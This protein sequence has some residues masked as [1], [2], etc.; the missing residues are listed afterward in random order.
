MISY[1]AAVA[2]AL[3]QGNRENG[4][5]FY[6]NTRY[7]TADLIDSQVLLSHKKAQKGLQIYAVSD[8]T[9]AESYDEETSAIIVKN[10]LKYHKILVDDPECDV[11]NTILD[12]IDETNKIVNRNIRETGN[13]NSYGTLALLCVERES[14][15][16]CSVG[17]SRV[18]KFSRGKLQQLTEDHTQAQKMVSLGLLDASK[19]S[20]H[21]KR[22]K[23]T[24][25]FGE[26]PEGMSIE[27]Y[28]DAIVSNDGD[29]YLLCTK[30]FYETVSKDE[31]AGILSHQPNPA[32]AVDELMA[33]ATDKG[34]RDD[35]TIILVRAEDTEAGA[36]AGGAVAGAAA[37]GA[38]ST[39]MFKSTRTTLFAHDE[40]K[41]ANSTK[42]QYEEYTEQKEE[43]DGVNGFFGMLLAP[44]RKDGVKDPNKFWPSLI[45]FAVC[46]LALIV[47]AVFG[48]NLFSSN[49]TNDLEP[50]KAP[51]IA[52]A[53]PEADTAT[54]DSGITPTPFG[55]TPK[56]TQDPNATPAPTGTPTPVPTASPTPTT[57][58]TASPTKAP[59]PTKAPTPAPTPAP[60][61]TDLSVSGAKTQYNVGEEFSKDGM[62]VFAE[63]S[64]GNSKNVTNEVSISGFKSDAPGDCT[65]TVSFGGKSTSFTV[66]IIGNAPESDNP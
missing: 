28:M 19:A 46:I 58:P 32:D 40:E 59:A 42:K 5:N 44:F 21:I 2:S 11:P 6:F 64:D 12:Y 51:V 29:M 62:K 39:P 7:L 15:L 18:Y 55:H 50:T 45:I 56:P 61:V 26:M 4:D 41:P 36:I 47:L 43:S 63:Y 27:P 17:D 10:L 20:S 25:Y 8:G 24:Q 3:G 38:A 65:V 16:I 31:I 30:G 66:H 9:G 23:L 34:V 49:R 57:A 13:H 53:T 1:R 33:Y 52:T 22:N 14:T 60:T 37:A 48:Y 54:P 35:A